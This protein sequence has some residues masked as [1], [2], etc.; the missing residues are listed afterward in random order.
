[1]IHKFIHCP[2]ESPVH[3]NEYRKK[4]DLAAQFD[5]RRR[6]QRGVVRWRSVRY[7]DRKKKRLCVFDA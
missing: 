7:C 1:M 6:T 4:N 5:N 3:G 2:P